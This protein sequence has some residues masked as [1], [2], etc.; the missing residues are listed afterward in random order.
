MSDPRLKPCLSA[1]EPPRQLLLPLIKGA[2]GKSL[3]P[4]SS[5]G[6]TAVIP[7]RTISAHPPHPEASRDVLLRRPTL[8][9]GA[10]VSL[11][12]TIR[13]WLGKIKGRAIAIAPGRLRARSGAALAAAHVHCE[14]GTSL[15]YIKKGFP[16]ARK[17]TL[18]NVPCAAA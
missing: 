10:T 9:Y 5:V 17:E 16:A 7:H 4:C 12:P 13:H 3:S 15:S 18:G 11:A 1:A 6:G 2:L 8:F 14:P